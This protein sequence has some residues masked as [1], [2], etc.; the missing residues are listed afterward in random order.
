MTEEFNY[1]PTRECEDIAQR[2]RDERVAELKIYH[3]PC[4][5]LVDFVLAH[6]WTLGRLSTPSLQNPLFVR[7]SNKAPRECN[8]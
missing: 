3:R 1:N 7:R 6:W 5:H 4:R 8:R 2:Y